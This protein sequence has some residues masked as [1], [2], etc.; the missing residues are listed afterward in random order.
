MK[1]KK[2]YGT[3]TLK[4]GR[5]KHRFAK[6][7]TVKGRENKAKVLT[8][9]NLKGEQYVAPKYFMVDGIPHKFDE[10][11]NKVPLTFQRKIYGLTAV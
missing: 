6:P 2:S 8:R 10:N 11:G 9:L 4:K 3:V 5:G 1:G 7:N